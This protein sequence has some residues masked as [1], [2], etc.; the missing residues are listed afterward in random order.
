MQLTGTLTLRIHDHT[1]TLRARHR[2][3]K[4]LV[5]NCI[6]LASNFVVM[7]SDIDAGLPGSHKSLERRVRW[8][9]LKQWS[10]TY[11][12]KLGPLT[13][14]QLEES[15]RERLSTDLAASELLLVFFSAALSS[16]RRATI[17]DPFPAFFIGTDGPC[18]EDAVRCEYA[19][20]S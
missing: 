3:I 20:V 15:V 19:D 17:C 16:P 8:N 11:D 6:E 7:I 12:S 9:Q 18:Y 10:E 13:R 2:I 4:L 5:A 14:S 1:T